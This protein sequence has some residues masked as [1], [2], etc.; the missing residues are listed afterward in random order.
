MPITGELFVGKMIWWGGGQMPQ[1]RF[2]Q[3][4]LGKCMF[5][6]SPSKSALYGFVT[7]T[8][9]LNVSPSS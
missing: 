3:Y 1:F 9:N 7:A 6:S 2:R 8:L 5:I 4:I